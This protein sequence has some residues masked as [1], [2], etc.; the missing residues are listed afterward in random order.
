MNGARTLTAL[1]F[2]LAVGGVRGQEPERLP[3]P[4]PDANQVVPTPSFERVFLQLP[5]DRQLRQE[6]GRQRPQGPPPPPEPGPGP[7]PWV[8]RQWAPM[9]EIV[10]PAYVCYGRLYFEQI[11]SERYGWD[12]GPLQ[13][14]LSAGIFY[15]DVAFLPYHMGTEPCRWYECSAGYCLPGDPVPLLLYP[16]ELSATGALAE[17]GTVG[18]LLMIFPP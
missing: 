11:N 10:E 13:P 16:P 3:L 15:F 14:L 6:M 7:E 8:P 9:S 18:L 2:L 17:A 4:K 12:L 5:T 1:I